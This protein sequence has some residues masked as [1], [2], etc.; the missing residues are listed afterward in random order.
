MS[1]QVYENFVLENKINDIL[2]TKLDMYQFATK[3]ESLALTEGMKKVVNVYTASGNVEDLAMGE[4]NTGDISVSFEK[5]EYDIKTTQGR[6]PYFDEQAMTDSTAIDTGIR[7]LTDQMTNDLTTKVVAELRKATLTTPFGVDFNSIVD[8]IG[9]YPYE[10]EDGLFLFVSQD[11][12][13]EMRK[14]LGDDLKY[15]EAYARTGYIGSVAGVPVYFS[16]AIPQ[17]EA[18]LATKEAITIFVKKGVEVEQERDADKRQNVVYGRKYM[19]VA[20]TDATKVV[21]LAN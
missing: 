5:K 1:V 13:A 17:G 18:Y 19:V 14:A 21:K 15:V 11:D 6:F 16:K 4:G 2:M 8:A 10:V 3:D 20:L 7:G 12:K 9:K